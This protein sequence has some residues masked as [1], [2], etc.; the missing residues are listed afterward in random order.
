MSLFFSQIFTLLT[1]PPGN[2][3][4]HIVLVFSIVGPLQRAIQLQR[5]GYFSQMQRMVFGLGF[6]LGLQIILFIMSGLVWQGLL[7]PKIVLPPIDRAVTVLALVWITW[8]WAFPEPIRLADFATIFLS[9]LVL[10]L[11]G[12]TLVFW[13][14]NTG[15]SFNYSIFER[16][17]QV[18]SLAVVILGIL[19]LVL[20]R[21]Y[22]W[23]NGLAM[24]LLA[25]FGH[26]LSLI[27]PINGSF[28]G[29]V[30]LTQLAL[31]PILLT[32]VQRFLPSVSTQIPSVKVNNPVEEATTE[33]QRYSTDPKTF[34]ALMALAAEDK[35]D[36]IGYAMTRGI[37]QV[38]LADL[39]FLLALGDDKGLSFTC[40]Y[41]SIHEQ[42]LEGIPVN[43]DAIPQLANAI[44]RGRPLRLSASSSSADLKGLTKILRLSNPGHLLGV[45]IISRERG[46]VGGILILSPYS[47]RQWSAEDQAYLFNVSD[48]F[49]PILERGQ[50]A[51]LRDA[52]RDQASQDIRSAQEQAAEAKSKVEEMARMQKD[53][54]A[55]NSKILELEKHPIA[56]FTS[57]KLAAIASISRE[58]RQPMSSIVGYTDLLMGESAGPQD[59][60]RRKFTER[61]KTSTERIGSLVEDLMQITD[62]ETIKMEKRA[63]PVD[64]NI[65]IDNTLAYTS[66]QIRAKNITLRLDIPEAVPQIQGDRDALQQIFIHLLQ[67]ATAASRKEGIITLRVQMQNKENKHLISI[68]VTDTGGGIDSKDIPHVFDRLY[69]SENPLIQGLGEPA[70]GLSIAK[71]L[72]EAQSGRIWVESDAGTGSTFNVQLP[73]LLEGEEEK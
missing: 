1:T 3:I 9:L 63:E 48:L 39:C 56:P 10:P 7:D 27:W 23:G 13:V 49:I 54:T 58:L 64:L 17:W 25:F 14:Q 30:R 8:L 28:P 21:T 31:F 5:S 65:L 44:Q 16:I 71:S 4:Y 43:K 2:L 18:F 73:V 53:L 29:F 72:V 32:I 38:M 6:L 12:L 67:N 45:P 15:T 66:T 70:A 24:L 40:G 26:L 35:A 61:I 52:E 51:S 22:G 46:P 20:R 60:L 59:T 69:R 55:A 62:A 36:K 57:E 33:Q 37:A 68:Q 11:F 19:V 42:D 47:N 34:H 41:D 50:R